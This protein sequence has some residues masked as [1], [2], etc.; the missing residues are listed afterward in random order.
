MAPSPQEGLLERLAVRVAAELELLQLVAEEVEAE[1]LAGPV[2]D[3]AGIR[4]A[5]IAVGLAG[6]DA[7]D[8]HPQQLVDRRHPFGVAFGEVVVDGDDVDPLALQGVEVRRQGGDEGLA[9]AGLHLGD[10]AVVDGR[11]ADELDVVMPLADRPLGGLADQ[12]EGL[13]QQAVQRVALAG[14]EPERVA[15]RG[16]LRRRSRGSR[17]G[18]RALTR[19]A[20]RA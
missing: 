6:L 19:S 14:A 9:L 15:P 8:G 18:S 7:A 10:G 2:G 3:V 13:D 16:Q 1:L 11:A 4:L 17:V 12:G 5:A 20:S